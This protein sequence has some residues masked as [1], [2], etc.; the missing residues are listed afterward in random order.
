MKL[1]TA[2]KVNLFPK[3]S[4]GVYVCNSCHEIEH[5]LSFSEGY[6]WMI[7]AMVSEKVFPTNGRGYC[8]SMKRYP[9]W[10]TPD[11]DLAKS[12]LTAGSIHR[13]LYCFDVPEG[14]FLL[15]D[16]DMFTVGI[17]GYKDLLEQSLDIS[18]SECLQATTFVLFKEWMRPLD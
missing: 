18:N 3:N 2:Q 17:S 7:Q 13:Q 12:F 10:L 1:Y 11:K 8:R 15:T 9:I 5:G 4:N 6:K 14:Y 16:F